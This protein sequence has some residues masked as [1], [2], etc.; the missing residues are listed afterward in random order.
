MELVL[1][2]VKIMRPIQANAFDPGLPAPDLLRAMLLEKPTA[3][4]RYGSQWHIGN[5]EIVDDSGIYF[6]LGRTTKATLPILLEGSGDFI[7]EQYESAPYTHAFVDVNREVIA[8][9]AKSSVAPTTDAMAR[10]LERL[11]ARTSTAQSAE[12]AISVSPVSEPEQLLRALRSAYAITSFTVYFT[13]PNPMDVNDEFIKPMERLAQ[14][15]GGESGKTT[16][17]GAALDPEPLTDLVRSAASSGDDAVALVKPEPGTR[18]VRRSL[19]GQNARIS[20]EDASTPEGRARA[21]AKLR[22]KHIDV[23]GVDS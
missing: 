13:R 2:R 12:A 15:A 3:T 22:R 11:L 4:S 14:A 9:A 8:I 18:S 6:A 23:R 20:E 10:Q 21:L 16:I 5:V 17:R 19:R 7:E 1:Y